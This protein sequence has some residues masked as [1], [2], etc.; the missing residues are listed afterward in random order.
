MLSMVLLSSGNNLDFVG[1]RC[2]VCPV[3]LIEGPPGTGKTT[4]AGV[5]DALFRCQRGR[6]VL[7]VNDIT[8]SAL[9][10]QRELFPGMVFM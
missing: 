10:N 4:T 6:S 5:L 3:P 1:E 8:S 7:S 9:H 2:G